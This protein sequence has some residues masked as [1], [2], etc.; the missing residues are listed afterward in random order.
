M[1]VTGDFELPETDTMYYLMP[2]QTFVVRVKR[3]GQRINKSC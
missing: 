2:N 1:D 3:S